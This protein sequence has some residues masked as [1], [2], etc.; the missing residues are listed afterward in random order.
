MCGVVGI[1]T[2]DTRKE[3][4]SSEKKWRRIR[5]AYKV[6]RSLLTLQHRGQDAAGILSFDKENGKFH[7]HKDLGLV[8]E[9]FD[10]KKI[11]N[12]T[13]SI[14]IGQT[15]YTTIGGDTQDDLQ[16]LFTGCPLGI[17]L[18][19]NGNIVNYHE[20]SKRLILKFQHKF[21]SSNDL[22][23]F[24]NYFCQ[25]F[26]LLKRETLSSVEFFETI[27]ETIKKIFIDFQGG[28]ALI[29]IFSDF[30]LMA[31]RDPNG[32]RPLMLGRKKILGEDSYCVCS[33]SKTLDFLGYDYV[34]DVR[35][36]EF[37]LITYDNKIMSWIFKQDIKRSTTPCM[38]EWIYFSSTE[39]S[40][41]NKSVYTTRFKLGRLL[42]KK[43]KKAMDRGEIDPV[44]ICPVPS[45]SRTAAIA[46][47]EE[48]GIS[49]REVLIKNRYIQRSFILSTQKKREEAVDL[50]LSFVSKEIF[51]KKI[52]LVDDSIVRGTTSRK[53]INLLRKY[54]V[55]EVTLAITCPPLRYP[56]Y[57]GIDFPSV[58]ELVAHNS[59]EKEI[60]RKIGVDKIIYLDEKDICEGVGL[61]DLCFACIDKKY[62]TNVDAGEIFS[63]Y[64]RN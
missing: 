51:G 46:V 26:G 28:Y 52:L 64:R 14:A 60:A 30:G 59:T 42:A 39:S 16:P 57:Y 44:M 4:S 36:G 19:H 38:F 3:L 61:K 23:L 9:V 1:I 13:G 49:Y 37:L 32:I 18:V 58:Q 48:I 27:R 34:R 45:T 56:C 40:I 55:A 41:E 24:L 17:G 6:Y 22:E 35:P 25:Y 21:L 62:P 33:E 43:I 53:I 20:L 12:L 8:S 10:E 7:C 54:G 5:S 47:A 15:R 63:S 50:K 2:P 11:S 31:M 29:G